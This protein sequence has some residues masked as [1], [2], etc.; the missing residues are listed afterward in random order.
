MI[1]TDDDKSPEAPLPGLLLLCWWQLIASG[2]QTAQS[3]SNSPVLGR[4]PASL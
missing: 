1:A 2:I 4:S 3:L